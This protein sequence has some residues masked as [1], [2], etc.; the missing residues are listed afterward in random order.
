MERFFLHLSYKGTRYHGWQRQPDV[1]TIQQVLEDALSQIL[2][3]RIVLHGCGRTDKG[4]HA[5]Q[6]IAHFET[7]SKLDNFD[8]VQR[9]NRILPTDIQLLKV[10]PVE[11]FRNAQRHARSRSYHYYF[12]GEIDPFLNEVSSY[13]SDSDTWNL[14][15]MQ[16]A[17]GALKGK[18]DFRAYCKQPDKNKDTICAIYD[19]GIWKPEGR[20]QYCLKITG[21]RFLKSMI[22]IL[23]FQLWKIAKGQWSVTDLQRHLDDQELLPFIN[24]APPQGLFLS[25]VEYE[26]L[27][28]DNTLD[29]TVAHS[30]QWHLVDQ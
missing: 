3:E 20:N 6:Y 15:A 21:N 14:P 7:N 5:S 16:R 1:L 27:S 18:H 30:D 10:I 12:H 17:C 4:V 26:F 11:R 28:L 25:K 23:M 2:K 8:L 9:A 29:T 22:R 13:C 24:T 19:C